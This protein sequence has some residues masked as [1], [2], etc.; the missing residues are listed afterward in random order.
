M[1]GLFVRKLAGAAAAGVQLQKIAPF[2]FPPNGALWKRG[3]YRLLLL[4]S[5]FA[6]L[7]VVS[8][9]AVAWD[10]LYLGG[11]TELPR[12]WISALLVES[13]ALLYFL[14]VSLR[15][16]S[17]TGPAIAMPPG[18]NPSSPPSRIVSRTILIVSSAVA[19]IAGRD[20]L[21][22]G[23]IL[24]FLPYDDI[25]LEWTNSFLHSPPEGSPEYTEH[26]LQSA[27]FIGDKYVSQYMALNVLLLCL[28]KFIAAVGIRYGKD[29][30]GEAQ[31]KMIWTAQAISNALVL[32]VVRLFAA[33]ARSASLD[34]RW[35]IVATAYETFIL[36]IY[37]FF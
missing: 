6:D 3:D 32:F 36:G 9:L 26:G 21:F 16:K 4:G 24:G 33:A 22:P 2:L 23:K 11:A 34:V 30:R 25:Y 17:K 13:L 8:F 14:L 5:L 1:G 20:L 7:C 10:D 35:Y 31:A 29:G 19:V 12:M 37:G 15:Y 18:K 28:F 27:L